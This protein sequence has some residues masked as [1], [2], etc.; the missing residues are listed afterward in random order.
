VIADPAALPMPAA[1]IL[2]RGLPAIAKRRVITSAFK[3]ISHKKQLL[4]VACSVTR[5]VYP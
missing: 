4:D 2:L 5:R 1:G 3:E